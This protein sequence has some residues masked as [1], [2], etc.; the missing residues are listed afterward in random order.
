MKNYILLS[1]I[2]LTG[3]A[4]VEKEVYRVGEALEVPTKRTCANIAPVERSDGKMDYT[5]GYCPEGYRWVENAKS[6][7]CANISGVSQ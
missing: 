2:F 3:C 4:T 6:I 5:G 7:Y 1:L